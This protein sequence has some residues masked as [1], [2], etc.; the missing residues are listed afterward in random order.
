MPD[1]FTNRLKQSSSPYLQ[2]HAHNPVDWREWNTDSLTLALEEDKPIIVSIGY[3]ACHWCHVMEHESFEDEA[4]AEIM[5]AHFICIKVDR[6]ER[7]DVDQVY[8]DAVQAMGLQGGWPLNVFLTPHQKPFYGGTYFPANGWSKLLTQIANVFKSQRN[9]VEKSANGFM[10]TLGASEVEKY[11]L[12]ET[13]NEFNPNDL[14][15]MFDKLKSNFD[16]EKGGMNRAPK[17][18]MPSIYGFLL[19]ENHINKN[20]EGLDHVKLTLDQMAMGGLYDQIG[21]GFTRYS[22]DANWFVPHFE[23]MLYDNGQLVSLYSEA[24]AVTKSSLYKETV[25]QTIDWLER[26]MT[27]T[28][29]GFYAA[30]DADSEG[31]EGKFYVWSSNEISKV[32][33]ADAEIIIDYYNIS[34]QGNWETDKNIP[35]RNVSDN[36]FAARHQLDIDELKDLVKIC[37]LKLLQARSNR[38]RPG[39][40]DKVLSGWNGLMLKGLI[41]AYGAFKEPA[42]LKMALKNAEFLTS[43][44]KV[45]RK[46]FR[47][48]KDEKASI[49]GYL[50][51]YAAVAQAFIALYQM[52]F[53]EKWLNEAKTLVDYSIDSFYDEEEGF[54][55]FTDHNSEALIARKKEIFDNVIPSSNSIM[56]S[57]LYNLSLLMDN[58][59]YRLKALRMVQKI[60]KLVKTEPQYL[61]NWAS[62]ISNLVEPTAEVVIVG[63]NAQEEALKLHQYF[64][65][66]KVVLGAN[67]EGKSTLPLLANRGLINNATTFYVCR[68]KTCQLPVNS[69]EEALKQII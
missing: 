65:P 36:D 55:F 18:P 31:E 61:T 59:D 20:T 53:D 54:F 56:A 11:G 37:N 9:E 30:L 3:S 15:A 10:K 22:T 38:V 24:Y 60:I 14:A 68:N 26:E 2:Q 52:T 7:P 57:N 17:F 28:E 66:N 32:L 6:E 48:Y 34:V 43:K 35:F 42:F 58:K 8:M 29:G 45:G 5:N 46:L 63:E 51:D 27:N 64:L 16:V 21:G 13:E 40:D 67:Q 39:L 23:K 19:R 50:E 4:I 25:Y 44:M 47:N 62:V 1:K 41:D 49:D 33:G 69:L 12:I